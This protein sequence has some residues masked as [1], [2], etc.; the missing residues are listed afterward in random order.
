MLRL[1]N[2]EYYNNY[3]Y[4]ER[5][6]NQAPIEVRNAALESENPTQY[7][8]PENKRIQAYKTMLEK[9]NQKQSA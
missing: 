6:N 2:I 7:P 4:Q 1:K 8:I 3:R 9:K 5:F